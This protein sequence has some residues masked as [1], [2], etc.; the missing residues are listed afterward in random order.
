MG[1][2][3]S[4]V[5]F[6]IAGFFSLGLPV[7]IIE[8]IPGSTYLHV[9]QSGFTLSNLF[10]RI[11]V[12]WSVVDEFFVVTLKLTGM[13]VHEMVGFNFVPSYDRAELGRRIAEIIGK[14]EGALP[15][16]YGKKA[17]ELAEFMNECL[18]RAKSTGGEQAHRGD[19]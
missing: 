2:T 18:A 4:W 9:D 6:L 11:T 16:T 13:K 10:R 1:L 8:L 3:K 12:P 5:G 19:A 15:D 7:A 17:E 14:C